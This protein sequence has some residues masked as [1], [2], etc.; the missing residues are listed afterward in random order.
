MRGYMVE[1]NCYYGGTSHKGHTSNDDTSLRVA[2]RGGQ[3]G[4]SAP[5]W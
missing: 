1:H 4:A 3:G 5:P 2:F